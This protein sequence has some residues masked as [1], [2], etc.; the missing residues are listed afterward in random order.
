MELCECSLKKYIEKNEVNEELVH[1]LMRNVLKGLKKIHDN[2]IVHMDIKPENILFSAYG[3]FK[4]ADLGLGRVTTNLLNEIPEG[5]CRY[6]ASEV[7]DDV[8]ER[9]V[10]DLTKADIFSLGATVFEI[11]RRRSLPKNGQEWH[12]I[13]NGEVEVPRGYSYKTRKAIEAMMCRDPSKRPSAAQ[14]LEEV[15]ISDK[16][17]EILKWKNYASWLEKENKGTDGMQCLKKRKL[18]F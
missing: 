1:R 17:K 15:F 12:D 13:R 4:L 14:L 5:D 11:M 16:K 3:K 9:C 7:L 2:S 10:P 8:S 18:S 6:L